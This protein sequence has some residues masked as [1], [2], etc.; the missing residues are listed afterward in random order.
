[1][2]IVLKYFLISFQ[3]LPET[4]ESFLNEHCMTSSGNVT[5][6]NFEISLKFD[7]LEP[8]QDQVIFKVYLSFFEI[9]N[10]VESYNY[11]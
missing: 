5:N 3:I 10:F 7:F 9:E 2:H 11:Y 4:I 1:M 6:A 8:P